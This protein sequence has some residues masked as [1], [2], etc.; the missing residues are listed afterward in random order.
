MEKPRENPAN[1]TEAEPIV[2]RL[3]SVSIDIESLSVAELKKMLDAVKHEA[4]RRKHANQ[5]TTNEVTQ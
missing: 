2:L 5:T 4:S 1:V 3:G